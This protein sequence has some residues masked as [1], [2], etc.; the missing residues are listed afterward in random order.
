MYCPRCKQTFEEGSRRFCPTDGARLITERPSQ[1]KAGVFANLIPQMDAIRE[2]SGALPEALHPDTDELELDLMNVAS[3]QEDDIYFELDDEPASTAMDEEAFSQAARTFDSLPEAERSSLA[4]KPSPRKVSPYDISDGGVNLERERPEIFTGDFDV[5]NPESFVGRTVKS[6]YKVTDFLGGDEAGLAYIGQDKIADKKVLVRI[7]L[8]EESDEIVASILSEERVSLSHLSHPNIA[9]LI[10]SG[11]FTNGIQFLVSTYFDGLSVR[12]ILDIYGKFPAERAGRI[13]RQAA[14]ALGQAHQEGILHRDVR[15]ENLIIDTESDAEQVVLVNFGA[16][17]GEPTEMNAAYKA[18]EI[19]DGRIGTAASDI[20]SLAVVGYEML[21][22][23]LPFDGEST[24]AIVRSQY[25]GL[26]LRPTDIDDE[27]PQAVDEVLEKAFSYNSAERYT[28]ARDFGDAFA[29]SVSGIGARQTVNAKAEAATT[30]ASK[31]IVTTKPVITG[32]V[33]TLEPAVKAVRSDEPAWKQRSPEPPEIENPRTRMAWIVG[34][35]VLLALIGAGWWYIVSHPVEQPLQSQQQD[36]NSNSVAVN[37]ISSTTEMPP[38]PRSIPQPPNT[39]F[40]ENSKASLKGDL[41]ANF[42]GFSLYYPKD[43]KSNG[44]Q[45]SSGTG[46]GKFLDIS[47]ETPD[48]RPVE[49]ML[50]SYYPSKGTYSEDAQN[51]PQL[52]KESNET[53]KKILPGY[54]DVSEGEIK[55]NGAWHAYE[56]K[57]QG[58]GTSPDGEKLVVWGRRIFIPAARPGTRNGFEITMLATS[59]SEDVKSVDDVGVKGEMASILYSFEPN[60]NF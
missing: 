29:N 19:L 27:L 10:D 9:R 41:L 39:N 40:F 24:K 50:V 54:Q 48:G 13:I 30:A 53:L 23:R 56:L 28:K 46:R 6:R 33:E 17:N 25:A 45:P 5:S 22:G 38:L 8:Q 31:P 37:T 16:S 57:F 7:L 18:P 3:R 26:S 52:V 36:Q 42:V 43:W 15:P 55:V 44:A 32:H 11:T 47:R 14:S 20:F 34:I 21:T 4:A 2:I 51:F 1:P 60:Q 35:V 59:L 58:G 12:D 49:Q